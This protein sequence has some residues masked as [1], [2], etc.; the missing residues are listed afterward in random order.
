MSLTLSSGLPIIA[1]SDFH[2]PKQFK[3]WKTLI[4]CEL[5]FF[6][7]KLAVREQRIEFIN[8]SELNP[9]RLELQQNYFAGVF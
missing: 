4:D 8:F 9:D 1:N 3:S 7:L 2:H 6:S 5:D